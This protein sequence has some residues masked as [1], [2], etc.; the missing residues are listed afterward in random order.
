MEKRA[1]IEIDTGRILENVE[2]IKKYTCR[3]FMACV[4]GDCYGLGMCR[5][6]GVI[7]N[8]VDCFGVATT[9]EAISLRE[10]G[11]RKPILV[12]GP[13]LPGD[14]ELLVENDVRIALFNNELLKAAEKAAEKRNKKTVVHIKVDTGLGRIGVSAKESENFI[15]R[16]AGSKKIRIEGIFTHF[17]TADCKDTSY[18]KHQLREFNGVLERTA[19]IGIPVKH[20]ANS[21]SILNLPETYR[22]FDMTRIGLLIFGIYPEVRLYKKLPLKCTVKGFCRAIYVKTVPKGTPLSYGITYRTIRTSEIATT[23]IGYADGLRRLLSNNFY[24]THKGKK[25][26]ITGNICMD[27]TLIDVTGKNVKTGDSLQVF[28]D[29]FEIEKMADKCK[30]VPQEI[31]CGFTSPRMAK[32]YKK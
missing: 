23:G 5:I 32:I 7:E 3:K 8:A 4:K 10:A 15:R 12:M 26:K 22:N 25:I 1:W 9:S 21:P 29:N 17:A 6:S 16:V 13:V 27:Q 18:A 2:K 31:L 20:I 30:T 11:I 14:V 28:G 19:D 24:F